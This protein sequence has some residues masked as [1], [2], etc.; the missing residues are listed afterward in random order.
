M[1][2]PFHFFI[3]SSTYYL[4]DLPSVRSVRRLYTGAASTQPRSHAAIDAM[5]QPASK[6][7][8]A[9]ASLSGPAETLRCAIATCCRTQASPF[10]NHGEWVTKS[11]ER[12]SSEALIAR[13][14]REGIP[15]V[16]CFRCHY[17][18]ITRTRGGH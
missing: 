17:V 5:E 16:L 2:G 8:S 10:N 11:G 6:Q 1:F 4:I 3:F 9:A 18:M 7:S 14:K 12:A 13:S 15:H